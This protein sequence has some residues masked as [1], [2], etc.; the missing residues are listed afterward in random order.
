[1]QWTRPALWQVWFSHHHGLFTWTPVWL[2]AML[3][4]ISTPARH[5]Q[6]LVPLLVVF[7]LES[8]VNAAAR[9]W[10]GGDA[11][12]ARRFMGLFPVL[13]LG[14]AGLAARL[15]GRFLSIAAAAAAANLALMAAYVTG[16]IPHG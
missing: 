2:L 3:G 6:R 13:A 14:L 11:F 7:L 10:W 8:Y 15:G 1:M 16:R 5:R 4:L 9:D 12:G